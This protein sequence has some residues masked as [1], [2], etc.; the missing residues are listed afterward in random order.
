MTQNLALGGE[1]ISVSDAMKLVDFLY[2][3]AYEL[4]GQFYEQ[5]R[6]E[7]FRVNWPNAEDFADAN[8]KAFVQQARADFTTILANPKT[9]PVKAK[10]IYLALLVERA[11]AAGLEQ[12]GREADTQLQIHKGTQAFEGDKTENRKIMETYGPAPNLR[13][14]LKGGAAKIMRMH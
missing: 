12:I 7:K 5:N 9:D 13:A 8:K 1:I 6:S 2:A 11:F 3:H 4:A 14:K 10:R